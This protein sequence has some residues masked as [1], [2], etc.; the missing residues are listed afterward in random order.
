MEKIVKICS[1]AFCC[2]SLLA[3]CTKIGDIN[4]YYFEI[5]LIVI[6]LVGLGIFL[7]KKNDNYEDIYLYVERISYKYPNAFTNYCK[8]FGF[9]EYIRPGEVCYFESKDSLN[10]AMLIRIASEKENYWAN[11]EKAFFIKKKY[12]RGYESWKGPRG[13]TTSFLYDFE[14]YDEFTVLNSEAIV[15]N[16]EKIKELEIEA[17]NNQFRMYVLSKKYTLRKKH[18]CAYVGENS[19]LKTLN[20]SQKEYVIKNLEALDKY[21]KELLEK[22]YEKI[23][24][25]YPDGVE[26]FC[27]QKKDKGSETNL[28]SNELLEACIN[29]EEEIKKYQQIWTKYVKEKNKYLEVIKNYQDSHATGLVDNL[30]V[31]LQPKKDEIIKL[32]RARLARFEKLCKTIKIEQGWINNQK[33]FART[34]R[35]NYERFLPKWG[36]YPYDLSIELTSFDKD[37]QINKFRLWHFFYNFYCSDETLDYTLS[38]SLKKENLRNYLFLTDMRIYKDSMFDGIM[39]FVRFIKEKTGNVC[40]VFGNSALDNHNINSMRYDHYKKNVSVQFKYYKRFVVDS[41]CLDYEENFIKSDQFNY[42]KEF[43]S[44]KFSYLRQQLIKENVLFFE[45]IEEIDIPENTCIIV[46]EFI[47]PPQYQKNQICAIIDKFKNKYPTLCYISMR[48]EFEVDE[49]T[50]YMEKIRKVQ[51]QKQRKET[52]RKNEE[53]EKCKNESLLSLNKNVSSWNT[54]TFGLPYNYLLLYYPITCDFEAD[55]CE[56]VNRRLVWDFKNTPGTTL[57]GQ[58]EQA[59]SNLLPRLRDLLLQTFNTNIKLLT[60]V[61]IPA[62]SEENNNARFKDFSERLTSSLQMDNAFEHIQIIK[63]ASPKHLGGIGAPKLHFDEDY[64]KGRNILLFDDIITKGNSMH[65]FKNKLES[66]G[67][68]V[69]AGVSIGKTKHER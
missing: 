4:K 35:S 42:Y 15:Q 14:R 52:E 23:K 32:G 1:C 66:L 27:N 21:I 13:I 11:L 49:S 69:I 60:L 12:P 18:V 50:R 68:N 43:N 53:A 33:I 61:C 28:K 44:K 48:K 22:E 16:E 51:E 58:H 38:P 31:S 34:I 2:L 36:A 40:V 17:I 19:T 54:F 3:S 46:V 55:E 29:S 63:D 9:F 8:R 10:T 39:S 57:S 25:K 24:N 64:F 20:I 37:K 56:W 26:F 6:V 7:I 5:I 45:T 41:E 59:L 62:S 67:A 65:R 47:T 30:Y